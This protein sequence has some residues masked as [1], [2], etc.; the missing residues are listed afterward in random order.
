MKSIGFIPKDAGYFISIR[1]HSIQIYILFLLCAAL[2][3]RLPAQFSFEDCGQI[4]PP[5][6]PTEGIP[7]C[8]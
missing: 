5:S 7:L 2:P 8:Q 6:L 4:S 1:Q 3:Q